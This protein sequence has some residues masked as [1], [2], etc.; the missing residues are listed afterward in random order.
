MFVKKC[1][2]LHWYGYMPA[3]VIACVVIGYGVSLLTPQ[4]TNDLT[5][6]TVFDINRDR[7]AEAP[8][9]A[10]SG[11]GATVQ[12]KPQMNTHGHQFTEP[13]CD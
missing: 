11:R 12:R 8:G 10:E 9:K 6:L 4:R 5:G 13:P 7:A 1:T 2:A 3:A